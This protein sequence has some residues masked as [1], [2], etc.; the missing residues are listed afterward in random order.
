MG[1]KK[2][3]LN[4][5]QDLVT[6]LSEQNAALVK[7]VSEN[8]KDLSHLLARVRRLESALGRKGIQLPLLEQ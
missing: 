5:L 1:K 3:L 8:S 6:N 7:T 2:E 4:E